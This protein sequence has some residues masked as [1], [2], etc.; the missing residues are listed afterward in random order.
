MKFISKLERKIGKFAIPNLM[1]ILIACYVIG[2][3]FQLTYPGFLDFLTLEPYYIFKGQ[4]WRLLTWVIVPESGF[5]ILFTLIMLYFYYSIGTNLEQ[6]WGEFRFN[7][8]IFGGVIFTDIAAVILYFVV[9]SQASFALSMSGLFST[10]YINLSLFLAFALTYPENE[11][12]FMFVVP[13]KM[14]WM[15]LVYLILQIYFILNTNWVGRTAIIASL[16][17]FILF[18][19]M[20][21]NYK[22]IS[23]HEIKRKTEFK[24]QVRQVTAP[25]GVRHRCAICG[26]TDVDFPDLEFRFCSKCDGNFE[27]CQDHLFT[28]EHVKKN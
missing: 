13:V 21:R 9:G 10:Y 14:K 8:Y 26:R 2:Y 16:F 24:K 22:K 6:T 23:P 5:N 18:Y 7:L 17:N 25:G 4:V 20:T 15:G 28:H 12:L 19:L 1:R 27:Y 3:V 11:V